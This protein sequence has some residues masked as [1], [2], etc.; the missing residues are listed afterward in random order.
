MENEEHHI[1]FNDVKD[2]TIEEM[3]KGMEELQDIIIRQ[4]LEHNKVPICSK[5]VI[6]GTE[7]KGDLHGQ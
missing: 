2:L 5:C 4:M 6:C 3:R 1:S 7:Y